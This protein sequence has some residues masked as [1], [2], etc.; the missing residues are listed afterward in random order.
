MESSKRQSLLRLS[1]YGIM[2]IIE[3]ELKEDTTF[4]DDEDSL[5]KR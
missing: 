3:E 2:D 4:N 1:E 5:V